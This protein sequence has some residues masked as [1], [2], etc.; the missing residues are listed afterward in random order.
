[1]STLTEISKQKGSHS[2]GQLLEYKASESGLTGKTSFGQFKVE[3]YSPH[4]VRIAISSHKAFDDFSYAVIAQPEQ[5]PFDLKESKDQLRL[6]TSGLVLEIT[7]DPVRFRFLDL[8]G[9]VINEDEPAFGT[10]WIGDEI[11]TYKKLRKEE[12]FIGL[13]EKTGNLDRRGSGYTN[14]NTDSFAYGPDGDPLYC[15]MPFYIGLH[16]EKAYGIYLDNSFKSHFN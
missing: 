6:V 4:I 13:G 9:E 3:L 7:K 12:R 2:L 11:T 1:M 15:T 8:K 14:W 16:D 10:S 5:V